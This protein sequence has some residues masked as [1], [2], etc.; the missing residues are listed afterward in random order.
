M[1]KVYTIILFIMI[2]T[3]T[4]KVCFSKVPV[5][6]LNLNCVS[7]TVIDQESGRIL[8][9]K[10]GNKIL[11]MASTTKIMTAIIAIEKGKLNDVVTVSTKAASVSGSSAGLKA[12]EKVTLEELLYGLMLESGNDA[13]VAI[14]EHIGGNV[15]NFIRMMNNKAIELGALNTSFVTPHG[16]DAEDHFT[17]ANDL[18]KISAYAMRN[19]VFSK[20]VATKDISYGV[21]GQF[22]RNYT[23]INKF[24][25]RVDNSDGIKTGFTGNAGKCLVASVRHKFGRYICVVLNSGDRWKDAEK[26]VKYATENYK[27]I[28]IAEKEEIIKSLFVYG[29]NSRNILI[30]AKDELFLP[31]KKEEKDK[32]NVELYVPSVMFAPIAKNEI[33]GNLV[34]RLDKDIIAKYPLYSDREVKRKNFFDI[35]KDIFNYY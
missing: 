18:A 4:S 30:Q 28:K 26:L 16:L 9:S 11:P 34:V 12:G 27:F 1:K 15:T 20:I 24:L 8:Y 25:F 31:I 17:T 7:A 23:N 35:I 19:E 14:A 2:F 32:I 29:G 5:P 6:A 22:K 33:V 21:S 3:S 13:A 10:N